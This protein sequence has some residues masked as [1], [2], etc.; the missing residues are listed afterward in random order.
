MRVLQS[1][2]VAPDARRELLE[3]VAAADGVD[4]LE[5]PVAHEGVQAV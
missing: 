4:D 3:D 2:R 5:D 1:G